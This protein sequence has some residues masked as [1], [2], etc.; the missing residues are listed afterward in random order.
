MTAAELAAKAIRRFPFD[1]YG[2]DDVDALIHDRPDEQEWIPD[3]A[4]RVVDALHA[5]GY[6]DARVLERPGSP[7]CTC[8]PEDNPPTNPA[9]KARMDHHCDCAAVETAATLLGAYS[10]TAHAAQCIHGTEMDEFYT[11]RS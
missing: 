11:E 9:T 5:A 4:G 2:L 6:R 3:L 10:R 8:D 1:N 7:L